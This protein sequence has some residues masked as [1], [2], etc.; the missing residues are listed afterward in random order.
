MTETFDG[1][2]LD[3]FAF[4]S[5]GEPVLRLAIGMEL[6]FPRPMHQYRT[7]VLEVWKR[8]LAWR[9]DDVMTWTR[10]GGG[11]KSR[12]M[13]KAAY[14][15]IETWLD[16]SR[17]YG[18]ICFINVHDGAFEHIGRE[19]FRVHGDDEELDL[20]SGDTTINFVQ[21]R[22]PLS[23]A[24]DPDALAARLVELAAPLE[25]ECGTAGLMLHTTPFGG[26]EL[27][28]E[29]RGIVTRFEGVE[30]DGVDKGRWRASLGLT[31]INWL[32][33]VGPQ[34]L[35]TLGG[36][37]SVEARAAKAAG[38]TVQR[39]G[40][41]IVLRAGP[42]PRVGDRNKPSAALDPYRE[43][44][45]IVGPALFLDEDYAFDH[46]SFDGSATV[47]WLQRFERDLGTP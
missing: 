11:N 23:T 36:A 15:T 40:R 44:H 26:G 3:R 6:Y 8:F 30:P 17:P 5:F 32:T 34:H 37:A 18:P 25:F 41:G 20:D 39:L 31:G 35:Q 12:K 9:G 1:V 28:K 2:D 10:L 43:V 27:W 42:R 16:G 24:D 46:D 4:D 33:F 13:N 22:V 29:V 21:I 19:S 38:I 7:Q 45:R 47:E 14:K